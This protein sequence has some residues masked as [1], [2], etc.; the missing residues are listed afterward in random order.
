[1]GGLLRSKIVNL[2]LLLFSVA[3][4]FASAEMV[5]RWSRLV[6]E[7]APLTRGS[8]Q[9]ANELEIGYTRKPN[10]EFYGEDLSFIDFRGRI[11]NL[12][13]RGPDVKQPKSADAFRI[14]ILGDSV[15]EGYGVHDDEAIW[16]A[17][18]ARELRQI[19]LSVEVINLAVSGYNT[20][21]ELAV[22]KHIGLQLEPDLVLLAVCLNDQEDLNM[23]IV[24]NIL[25]DPQNQRSRHRLS[26]GDTE[27][28]H[29]SALVQLVL[30]QV[31]AEE[32]PAEVMK[33]YERYR[34]SNFHS[35]LKELGEL[36][37]NSTFE[38][39]VLLFPV[40]E[41][42]A[43]VDGQDYRN[44]RDSIDWVTSANG[45]KFFD[46]MGMF[47]DCT[48]HASAQL[49]SDMYHLTLEGHSCVGQGLARLLVNQL[50]K[51]LRN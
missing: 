6:P 41:D 51:L 50:P 42:G 23:T 3:L 7:F 47:K 20:R 28:L 37:K 31:S 39:Q 27:F 8:F 40:F 18:L 21:Q 13:F 35:A 36:E 2:T 22:L 45:I 25:S 17:V 19:N 48:N 15:A 26:S 46:L 5:V 30:M 12:G 32:I 24:W 10:F 14:L 16:P 33:K 1:M 29:S 11:N 9:L 43:P 4:C 44:S 38:A 49:A 34:S